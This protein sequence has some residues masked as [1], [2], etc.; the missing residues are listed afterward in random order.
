LIHALE[1][2]GDVVNSEPSHLTR[3]EAE[4]REAYRASYEAQRR[5]ARDPQLMATL[6]QRIA[7]LNKKYARADE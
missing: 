4:R 5:A 7:E 6:S 1:L 2:P 3:A